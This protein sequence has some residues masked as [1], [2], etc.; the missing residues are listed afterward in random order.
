MG[1]TLLTLPALRRYREAAFLSQQELA[2]KAGIHRSTVIDIENGWVKAR[3]PTLRK[4]AEAL[5]CLPDDLVGQH[6]DG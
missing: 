1:R 4:L 5:K 3:L 6:S 2:E